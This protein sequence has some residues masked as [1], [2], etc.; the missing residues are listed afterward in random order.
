[1]A[2]HLLPMGTLVPK[3]CTQGKVATTHSS[4]RLFF[5]F[6]TLLLAVTASLGGTGSLGAGS[7]VIARRCC[8]VNGVKLDGGHG[9]HSRPD[10]AVWR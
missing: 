3:V 2:F 9:S 7:L 5:N 6:L 10:C 8:L 1:M 4:N